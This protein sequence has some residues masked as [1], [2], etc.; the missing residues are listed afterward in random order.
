MRCLMVTFAYQ[1]SNLVRNNIITQ[2]ILYELE[3][4]RFNMSMQII[5]VGWEEERDRIGGFIKKMNEN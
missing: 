4:F 2:A 5:M 3:M 1:N